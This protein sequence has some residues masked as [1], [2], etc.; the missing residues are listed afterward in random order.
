MVAVPRG[1]VCGLGR[2]GALEARIIAASPGNP[3]SVLPACGKAVQ[4]GAGRLFRPASQF[5][6]EG[7][8][9]HFADESFGGGV[10]FAVR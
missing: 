8:G 10:Q 6:G 5:G 3:Y 4:A 9:R 2:A 1:T 7:V